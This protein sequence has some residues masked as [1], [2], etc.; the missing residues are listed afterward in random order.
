MDQSIRVLLADDHPTVR[1]G[2]RVLLER[3][4][5]I[6][7][8]AEAEDGQEALAL[9]EELAPDVGVLDCELPDIEGPQVAAEIERLCPSVQVLALS[10]HD[11]ERYV[12]GMLDAG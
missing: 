1:V 3:A 6:D 2:L 9:V 5:D 8:V 12:R 11:D 10:A 4:P 7:V